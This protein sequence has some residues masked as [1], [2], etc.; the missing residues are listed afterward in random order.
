MIQYYAP[1]RLVRGTFAVYCIVRKISVSDNWWQKCSSRVIIT[2]SVCVIN[3]FISAV[4][5][6]I[7]ADVCRRDSVED[8]C[9]YPGQEL[10]SRQ[11]SGKIFV[12]TQMYLEFFFRNR[13]SERR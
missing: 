7:I 5:C 12:K 6:S 10:A 13:M 9:H 1:V 11:L 4:V 8:C 2:E 3:S